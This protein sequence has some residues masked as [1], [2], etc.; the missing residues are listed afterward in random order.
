[1]ESEDIDISLKDVKQEEDIDKDKDIDKDI[2][3]AEAI[4]EEDVCSNVYNPK[5][6][7]NKDLLKLEDDKNIT[8]STTHFPVTDHTTPWHQDHDSHHRAMEQAH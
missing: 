4:A 3:L 7:T 6:Q 5:C 1:M 2:N 8:I